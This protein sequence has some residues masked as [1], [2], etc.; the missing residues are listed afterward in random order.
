MG[1]RLGKKMSVD[2]PAALSLARVLSANKDRRTKFV[3]ELREKTSFR[4]VLIKKRVTYYHPLLEKWRTIK[5][6]WKMSMF[7]VRI[8]VKKIYPKKECT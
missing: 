1:R 4:S 7:A 2:A 5:T 3:K 6:E 8:Y